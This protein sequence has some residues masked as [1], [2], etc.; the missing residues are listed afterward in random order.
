[1]YLAGA[2]SKYVERRASSFVFRNGLSLNQFALVLWETSSTC[3]VDSSVLSKVL[4]GKRLFTAYQLHVFCQALNLKRSEREYLF[5]CLFKDQSLRGG[6]KL[7]IPFTLCAFTHQFIEGLMYESD[8]LFQ[9][10]KWKDLYDIS[11]VIEPYLHEYASVMYVHNPEDKLISMYQ[12]VLYLRTKSMCSVQNQDAVMR[13]TRMLAR[14]LRRYSNSSFAHLT[15]G[16]I[17]SF[18]ASAYRVL[19]LFPSPLNSEL[20]RRWTIQ[21]GKSA[22]KALQLLPPTDNE[23]LFCLRNLLDSSIM[24]GN[25]DVFLHYLKTAEHIL[26]AQPSTNFLS[27]MQLA[28]TIGKGKAIFKLDDPF[29]L[30]EKVKKHFGRDIVG[31]RVHELSDIKAELETYLALNVRKDLYIEQKIQRAL[32]LASEESERYTSVISW[33]GAQ[34]EGSSLLTNF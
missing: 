24:L 3:G 8:V 19:G 29:A 23:Y 17:Y 2:L 30:K 18:E 4:N 31:T 12:K 10:G 22:A 26:P 9:A 28:S 27:S 25:R 33:L 21:S 11:G 5:H 16:Y 6:L 14:K 13:E 20:N 34:F 15:D 1:M 32:T 7:H